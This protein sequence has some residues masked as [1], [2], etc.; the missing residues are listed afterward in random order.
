MND[1]RVRQRRD[2]TALCI[3]AS[4]AG[5]EV[6]FLPGADAS[7]TAFAFAARLRRSLDRDDD[8]IASAWAARVVRRGGAAQSVRDYDEHGAWSTEM[9]EAFAH[10]FVALLRGAAWGGPWPP[11]AAPWRTQLAAAMASCPEGIEGRTAANALD[12]SSRALFIRLVALAS[13]L[14]ALPFTAPEIGTHRPYAEPGADAVPA[15]YRKQT[16]T[17]GPPPDSAVADS[18]F[19]QPGARPAPAVGFGPVEESRPFRFVV[20]AL[21]VA[22]G[23]TVAAAVV[24]TLYFTILRPGAADAAKAADTT[25][26]QLREREFARIYDNGAPMLRR[27]KWPEFGARVKRPES[28]GKMVEVSAKGEP[29]IDRTAGTGRMATV[30][31]EAR[32][33][34]GTSSIVCSYLDVGFSGEW[35]L[36]GFELSVRPEVA[37]PPYAA[38]PEGADALAR[39][40]LYAFQ[41]SDFE[42]VDRICPGIENDGKVESFR[43][44]LLGDGFITTVE[45]T[46]FAE[47]RVQGL[48]VQAATY[49]METNRDRRSGTLKLYLLRDGSNWKVGGMQTKMS[50]Y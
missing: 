47:E 43:D 33:V 19:A 23:L 50:W 40:L 48:V 41:Q 45:R 29:R 38:T 31:Y 14:G 39:R 1:S 7:S 32:H 15:T 11:E 44:T 34:F 24:A 10:G 30:E 4:G 3:V 37:E 9:E 12:D 35:K 17:V 42:T 36:A 2:G 18:A 26:A 28:L 16:V 13:R 6:E 25:I 46:A 27:E 20:P 8:A 22:L 21:V 5:R 49:T